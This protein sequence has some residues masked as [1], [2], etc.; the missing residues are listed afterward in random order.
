MNVSLQSPRRKL[1]HMYSVVLEYRDTS[2]RAIGFVIETPGEEE[3]ENVL[4]DIT[5]KY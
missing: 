2:Q 1:R 4:G 3:A 5:L